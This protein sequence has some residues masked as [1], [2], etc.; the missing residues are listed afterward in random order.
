M[1][2]QAKQPMSPI[3]QQAGLPPS[4]L[5]SERPVPGHYDITTWQTTRAGNEAVEPCLVDTK[6]NQAEQALAASLAE[7]I[8]DILSTRKFAVRRA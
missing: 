7:I 2:G 6:A 4:T 1:Q 5:T 3:E 8:L